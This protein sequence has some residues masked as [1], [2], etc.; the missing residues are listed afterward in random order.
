MKT[1]IRIIIALKSGEQI[2]AE[3]K[4]DASVD[5][6]VKSLM[7]TIS[8]TSIMMEDEAGVVH[9]VPTANI[10]FITVKKMHV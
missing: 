4:L 8:D 10:N 3:M 2:K 9:I 6:V 1:E 5:M 7:H